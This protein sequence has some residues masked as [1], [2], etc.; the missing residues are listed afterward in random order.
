MIQASAKEITM[1]KIKY[2]K[3][4]KWAKGDL[5]PLSEWSAAPD[6]FG[7]YEIGQLSDG[8]FIARYCGRAAGTSLRQRLSK[9]FRNSHNPNIR[10]LRKSLHFRCRA[11]ETRQEAKFVEAVHITAL[12]GSD[13]TPYDWNDREEWRGH[14]T[15]DDF[16]NA[17]S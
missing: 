2:P 1:A 5:R 15:I 7:F 9:H 8:V 12:T 11:F 3:L 14:S 10:R 6:A 4:W 16:N 17:D 13:E